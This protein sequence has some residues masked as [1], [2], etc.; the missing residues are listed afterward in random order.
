LRAPVKKIEWHST[1]GEIEVIEPVFRQPGKRLRPFSRTAGIVCRGCSLPL[2]RVVTDFG[3]E[4]AFGRV[5]AQ[6]QE[7]YGITLAP[8]TIRRITEG[9]AQRLHENLER[10]R[11]YPDKPGVEF[12]IAEMD[13][14]LIPT[15]EIAP[16][17]ED[18]RKGKR[19]NWKEARLCLAH[20]RG[21][22]SPRFAAVFQE[23][24]DQAG[25]ALFDC[26][27]RAG[28]G[29]KTYVHAVGDGAVWI[30]EQVE[31]QFGAQGHYLVDFYHAC[32]Y[33]GKA[34]AGFGENATDWL[35]KHKALLKSGEVETVIH[36]LK[37][38]WE[39]PD[40][41]DKNAPVRACRRY[42][43]NRPGQFTYP[44]AQS[45]GLPIGSGE[46]ESAH[47]YVIQER[48]KIAGAWWSPDKAKYM[49]TL[50]EVRANRQWQ[51]Y[52][53]QPA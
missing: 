5:P 28:F 14:S 12:L 40:V 29:R 21:S 43:S 27:C 39:P 16:K 6:L 23:S 2:Q 33:L 32:E 25:E 20:E 24:V 47:R 50:R 53:R 7:H 46:I 17:A 30:Q 15:V 44:N 22:L 26:A 36:A 1:F 45:K 48:L 31:K 10:M 52:W 41:E 38:H 18:K 34:A 9:H 49:L 3:A 42:L 37:P 19:L 11:V 13:G 51:A 35:E 4:R 8:T